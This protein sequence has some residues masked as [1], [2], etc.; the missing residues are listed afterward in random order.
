MRLFFSISLGVII[1]GAVAALLFFFV[2][3][4]QSE[5][6]TEAVRV[7]IT[8]GVARPELADTIA[9]AFSWSW[10]EKQ[11]FDATLRALQWD[12]FKE[13]TARIL[14]NQFD[15][16]ETETETFLIN[17]THFISQEEDLFFLAHT[18]GE[19]TFHIHDPIAFVAEA[20]VAG[21]RTA[22]EGAEVFLAA[23]LFAPARF[24]ADAF[25]RRQSV[26]LPDLIPLPPQDVG[27]READGRVF[28]VFSTVYYNIGTADFTLIADPETAGVRGDIARTVFQRITEPGGAMRDVPVGVF[29]WHEEHLH[30]HFSDFIAYTLESAEPLLAGA[31]APIRS[32]KA[33]YCV[34]DVTRIVVPGIE[35]GEAQYRVCG[36]ERQGVSIGWGDTYFHTYGGQRIDITDL[37]SGAY[38][39][40]FT[41]NPEGLFEESSYANNTS[42][43]R[44]T[45]DKEAMTVSVLSTYPLS[46]PEFEHIHYEQDL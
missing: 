30:Y 24:A 43:A 38:T 25:V 32:V 36:R 22:P 33:T 2:V 10:G 35:A 8:D 18:G 11:R 23:N 6:D 3:S 20:L 9:E 42:Q 29:E 31:A 1:I 14:T 19:F 7:V 4:P 27:L 39:L 15:W 44:I 21:V 26:P 5:H 46:I 40:S 13:K 34:R 12:A 16:S 45:I 17:G 28:L 37:P 41:V